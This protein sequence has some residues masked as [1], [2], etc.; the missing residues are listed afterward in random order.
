LRFR[1]VFSFVDV[2]DAACL[3]PLWHSSSCS[4][5]A[6]A[7]SSPSSNPFTVTS[8]STNLL[9]SGESSSNPFLPASDDDLGGLPALPGASA[10][11]GAGGGQSDR[12]N[13]RFYSPSHL[14]LNFAAAST[15]PLATT[16]RTLPGAATLRPAPAFTS[17]SAWLCW[18]N[19]NSL[20]TSSRCFIAQCGGDCGATGGNAHIWS[21]TL[22][23]VIDLAPTKE[24]TACT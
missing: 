19:T 9:A 18:P 20:V 3:F 6:S 16:S 23:P 12:G 22:D 5:L 2:A 14:A 11:G 15:L 4:G 17:P 7:Q 24:L 13:G 1:H 21:L 10:A 8:S